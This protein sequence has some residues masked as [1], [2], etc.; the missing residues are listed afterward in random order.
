[1]NASVYERMCAAIA[2]SHS[3]DEA[4]S[5]QDPAAALSA[6]V[7]QARNTEP[8]RKAAEI[9]LRAERCYAVLLRDAAGLPP[10]TRRDA[11]WLANF[12]GKTP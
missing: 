1:M 7:A 11:A 9:R 10:R 6:Y 4:A 2:A 12:E 8:E 5:I 3:N